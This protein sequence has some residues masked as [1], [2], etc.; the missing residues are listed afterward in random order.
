MLTGIVTLLI[1]AWATRTARSFYYLLHGAAHVYVDAIK[2]LV[3]DHV[4]C[5]SRI[6]G[7]IGEDLGNQRRIFR[8]SLKK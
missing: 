1:T 3:F 6:F 4:S 2:A 7:R 8:R 5:L